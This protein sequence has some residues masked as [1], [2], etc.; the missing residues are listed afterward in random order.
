MTDFCCSKK[1]YV[2]DVHYEIDK[3]RQNIFEGLTFDIL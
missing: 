3:R 2:L 1:I